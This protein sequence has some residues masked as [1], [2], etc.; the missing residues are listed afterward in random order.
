MARGPGP[1]QPATDELESTTAM[2]SVSAA[3]IQNVGRRAAKLADAVAHARDATPAVGKK[4][5]R[6]PAAEPRPVAPTEATLPIDA[7]QIMEPEPV[8]AQRMTDAAEETIGSVEQA[9]QQDLEAGATVADPLHQ[10]ID[11]A[12][13]DA[14]LA[15]EAAIHEVGAQAEAMRAA[16]SR[17]LLEATAAPQGAAV[18]L[19]ELNAKVAEAM[20]SN[21]EANISFLTSLF[22][23]RSLAQAA[24]L[25]RHHMQRQMSAFASQSRE[26]T[27]L[28]HKLAVDAIGTFAGRDGGR[29]T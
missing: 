7:E 19:T 25:N 9:T 18:T 21:V 16:V 27:T 4:I 13:H 23:V 29:L 3:A 6:K 22:D 26:L 2:P 24:D 17:A 15:G 20:R 14:A 11:A 28:A 12:Q 10:M 5:S 8:V 1:R